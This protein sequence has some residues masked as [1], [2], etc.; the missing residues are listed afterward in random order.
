MKR[1]KII[2]LFLLVIAIVLALAGCTYE[3]KANISPSDQGGKSPY[4]TETN[5][6]AVGDDEALP[7]KESPVKEESKVEETK[8]NEVNGFVGGELFV[9]FIDVGQADCIL[10]KTNDNSMLIDAGNN[11]DA[12]LV[13]N[14]LRDN[15]VTKLDYVIGT[16]PHEDHIGGLDAVINTFDIGKI[17][18]PKVE[19]TTKTFEDVLCAIQNKGLKITTPVPGTV[20]SLGEATFTIL[21]PNSSYY[22]ELNNY[23]VVIK[24][25][26]GN[27]A[28]IFQGDAE[29]FSEGEILSNGYDV[30]ADVI[31]IGHHGSSSSTSR[32]YLEAVNPG[33]AV[34]MVGKGNTYGHPH[35]ET[36]QLLKGKGIKVYR[37]DEQGTVIAVSDGS[38]ITFNTTPESYRSNSQG[39]SR[40]NGSVEEKTLDYKQQI[41]YITKT[42]G[43]YHREDCKF[44]KSSKVEIDIEEAIKKGYEPC[45]VCKP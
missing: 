29:A 7:I 19:H 45:K 25:E 14:Y 26:Y 22:D 43:K 5:T 34:I 17:I 40:D 8:A 10:I 3:Q 23:S 9:H 38:K 1:I 24:L 39:G 21:A 28:F 36:L 16:H 41:V 30:S 18:M 12:K 13:V 32:S 6:P 11:E 44:L 42:G 4:W 31:K 2:S 35:R 20:Y 15:N 37:T 27:T 33:Y